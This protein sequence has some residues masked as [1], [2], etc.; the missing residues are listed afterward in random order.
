M[1]NFL[2]SGLWAF[3]VAE[4]SQLFDS[5]EAHNLHDSI[6][7]VQCPVYIG[8]AEDEIFFQGQPEQLAQVLG[9]KGHIRRFTTE[10]GASLHCQA[11]AAS[12]MNGDVFD[13][14]EETLQ[15]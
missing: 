4:P 12:L 9:S 8:E 14:L 2:I 15:I 3:N 5:V 11:G 1:F 6:H 7:N 10:E 13:W